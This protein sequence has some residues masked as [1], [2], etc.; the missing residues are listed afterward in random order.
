MPAAEEAK[1]GH[2][3]GPDMS[4]EEDGDGGPLGDEEEKTPEEGYDFKACANDIMSAVQ[5]GDVGS[6][7]EALQE[8]ADKIGKK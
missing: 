1:F 6:L 3:V 2:L 8:L 5:S 4:E 7:E